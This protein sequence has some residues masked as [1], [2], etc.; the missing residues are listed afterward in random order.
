MKDI[1]IFD[2]T[3]RDGEQSPGCSMNINEKL[4]IARQLQRMKV[5]IIE[6]GFAIASAGDFESV[7]AVAGEITECAIA[8]LARATRGDIDAAWGA[9]KEARRPIIHTFIATSPLHMEC[10]LR[11]KPEQVLLQIEEAVTYARSLCGEVEFSAEDASRSEREFLAR[12]VEMAIRCGARTVNIPDTVGYATPEEMAGL[13]EYLLGTVPNI[14]KAVVSVH[15]HNDLGMAVANSLACVRAGARQVE[16]TINGIGERAGNASLE[17]VVMGISTRSEYYGVGTHVDTTQIF[18]ASNRLSRITG[19]P[20]PPNKPIVGRNAFAHESGIH[21]HGVLANPLTYEIMTPES[22]GV[23]KGDLVLGKHSGKHA[24]VSK[25]ETLGYQFDEA[26]IAE[27]FER[28]KALADKKKEI[29]DYDI[30]AII[31][32][33]SRTVKYFELD[34]FVINTGNTIHPTCIIS[35]WHNGE[36]QEDV[37]VGEG[38]IF[39]AYSAINKITGM[40][41]KLEDYKISSVTEGDDALG[42]VNVRASCDGRSV[43]GRGLSTDILESSIQAY[44]HAANK[45]I[46]AGAAPY[47]AGE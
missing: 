6:A 19:I 13:I 37:A 26:L 23:L 5:D 33:K 4:K 18:R 41:M 47:G 15:C 12:C 46:S 9:V 1:I 3:L 24:F 20:I 21:Q 45:L 14:D 31:D 32:A 8:S 7:R 36:A 27:L 44:L 25:L 22:V 40:D 34:R 38:P 10:K 42:Q 43:T 17:E 39:A 28:F 35:L 29:T 2:T 30:E 16:C 11:M